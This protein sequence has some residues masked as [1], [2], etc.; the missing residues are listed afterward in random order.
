MRKVVKQQRLVH[1]LCAVVQH[2]TGHVK[3]AKSPYKYMA[4]LPHWQQFMYLLS[5]A[6][7]HA[8]GLVELAAELDQLGQQRL[9]VRCKIELLGRD[10]RLQFAFQLLLLA[11]PGKS[12]IAMGVF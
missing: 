5:A 1:L 8:V 4:V 9:P 6:V 10:E 3:N 11:L 2:A 12:R 7:Q